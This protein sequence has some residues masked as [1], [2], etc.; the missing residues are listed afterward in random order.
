MGKVLFT[1]ETAKEAGK[2]SGEARRENPV[3][4][5]LV[6]VQLPSIRSTGF[7][8]G[9]ATELEHEMTSLRA[10]MRATKSAVALAQLSSAYDKLFKA[11]QVLTGTEKPATRKRDRNS[12]RGG[13]VEPVAEIDTRNGHT[14][15]TQDEPFRVPYVLPG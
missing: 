10:K 1:S 7:K 9:E 11:W 14:P 8:N 3:K 5:P 13:M 15:H 6:S 12:G 4:I 2:K